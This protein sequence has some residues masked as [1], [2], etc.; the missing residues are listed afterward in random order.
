MIE[1]K[2][3]TTCNSESDVEYTLILDS[4]D[5]LPSVGEIIKVTE[6]SSCGCYDTDIKPYPIVWNEEDNILLNQK[7]MMIFFYETY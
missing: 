2:I 7:N 5:A 1:L 4:R 3:D 6:D